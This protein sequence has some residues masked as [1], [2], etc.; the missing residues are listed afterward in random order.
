MAVSRTV[1][2][3]SIFVSPAL[4]FSRAGICNRLTFSNFALIALDAEPRWWTE[5][6]A[7]TGGALGAIEETNG[8]AIDGMRS[9]EAYS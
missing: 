9:P 8:G 3:I 7:A 6:Y 1:L 5:C 4:R 2:I